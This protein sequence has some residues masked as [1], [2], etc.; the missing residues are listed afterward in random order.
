MQACT[1]CRHGHKQHGCFCRMKCWP[2]DMTTNVFA[3]YIT[4]CGSSDSSEMHPA[5][6]SIWLGCIAEELE[7]VSFAA[8]L[9]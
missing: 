5:M 4:T 7:Q 9:C 6:Y 8:G 1:G 2:M 3:M